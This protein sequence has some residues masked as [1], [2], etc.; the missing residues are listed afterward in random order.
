MIGKGWDKHRVTRRVS[1]C[2]RECQCD[3]KHSPS[4]RQETK[5]G[6]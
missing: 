5:A 4:L 3:W 2:C 6:Y 1:Y